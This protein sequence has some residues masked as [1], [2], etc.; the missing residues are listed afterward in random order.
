[1]PLC[2]ASLRSSAGR[3]R[4][5]REAPFTRWHRAA[6]RTAAG[7]STESLRWC[8]TRG[9][10]GRSL[11]L[12]RCRAA[13]PSGCTGENVGEAHSCWGVRAFVGVCVCR[14]SSPRSHIIPHRRSHNPP[15]PPPWIDSRSST[16]PQVAHDTAPWVEEDNLVDS[17][18]NTVPQV[19]INNRSNHISRRQLNFPN[20]YLCTSFDVGRHPVR[21]G[22]IYHFD[23]RSQGSRVPF[24]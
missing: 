18:L 10:S 13:S 5:Q 12:P 3:N 6:E 9:R 8:W 23:N 4:P 15:P 1:M 19:D 16:K 17:F 11:T 24:C 21:C 2:G 14:R 22:V 7:C 20:T